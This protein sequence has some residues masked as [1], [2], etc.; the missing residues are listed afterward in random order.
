MG[1]A[2]V[3]T[4]QGA[5]PLMRIR[6]PFF[7][8]SVIAVTKSASRPRACLIRRFA[9]NLNVSNT[10]RGASASL[11]TLGDRHMLD[12]ATLQYVANHVSGRALTEQIMRDAARRKNDHEIADMHGHR[13][14]ALFEAA[15]AIRGLP[16]ETDG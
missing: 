16:L 15:Q 11:S 1:A 3:L 4:S 8:C 2:R 14:A 5:K 6:A 7:T 12:R 10:K 9:Q 13:A